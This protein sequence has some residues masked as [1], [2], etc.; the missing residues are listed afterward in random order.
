MKYREFREKVQN[1]P[2]F[3]SAIYE[4]LTSSPEMLYVQV[5]H[6][7]KEGYVLKLKRGLYTLND[8]DRK[9]GLSKMLL[10]NILYV[11]S[12]V[13][14]EYALA[15]YDMIPEAT[16]AVTSISSKKTMS[17]SNSKGNFIYKNI[18][19][20]AFNGFTQIKD[21]FGMNCL[22]ASPEK[23]LLDYLYFAQK[24]NKKLTEDYFEESLRLQNEDQLDIDKLI[25]LALHFKSKNLMKILTIFKKWI[26]R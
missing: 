12:Y 4:S 22:I 1:Y 18:K 3:T 8:E 17:F 11:P 5:H 10:A 19:K 23:T 13:S 20:N 2:Y 6:W 25:S 16:Y 7:V 24:K 9:V 21:E 15:Y 26:K 14:L